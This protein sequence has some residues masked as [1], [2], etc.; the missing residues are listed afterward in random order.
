VLQLQTYPDDE[1]AGRWAS[2]GVWADGTAE[3]IYGRYL[4]RVRVDPSDCVRYSLVLFPTAKSEAADERSYVIFANDDGGRRR[5]VSASLN[6]ADQHGPSRKHEVDLTQ[7]HTV[8]VNW[9]K[10]LLEFTLDGRTWARERGKGV[11]QHEH[12]FVAQT[13]YTDKPDCRPAALQMDW[14]VVYKEA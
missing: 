8:G 11:P 5:T 12:T 10:G 6:M 14:L 4:A 7:W 3:Q 9:S 13:E 2:G 1:V